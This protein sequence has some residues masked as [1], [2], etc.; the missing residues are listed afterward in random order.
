MS[1][2]VALAKQLNLATNRDIL[3]SVGTI[4][5]L[6]VSWRS[7]SPPRS[8]AEGCV[9]AGIESEVLDAFLAELAA[10]DDVPT[11][12]TE[13]LAILLAADKLPKPDQLVAIYTDA[14]GESAL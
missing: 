10:V 5:V 12:V 13:S 1:L 9:V 8:K 6:S 11:R 2:G 3:P 7:W 4:R 14:S